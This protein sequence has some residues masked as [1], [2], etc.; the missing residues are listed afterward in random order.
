MDNHIDYF[1]Y[2]VIPLVSAGL[3]FLGTWLVSKNKSKET[4]STKNSQFIDQLMTNVE[5]LTTQVNELRT[6]NAKLH[7]LISD[8]KMENLKLS[9]KI[10]EQFNYIE[11]IKSYYEHMPVPAWLKDKE[12][13]MFFI[14]SKYESLF[15]VTKMQYQNRTD[16][17]VWGEVIGK[18][19]QKHDKKV[20]DANKGVIVSEK[21]PSNPEDPEGDYNMWKI[22][23]FPIYLDGELFGVGGIAI[24]KL[25]KTAIKNG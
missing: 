14:N 19:Y 2:V 8:L 9:T 5:F 7:S 4:D 16:E 10:S 24:E 17:E 1:K 15:G 11:I 21:V 3:T 20:M 23:K 25:N 12:S 13:R 6:D 22:L 18:I